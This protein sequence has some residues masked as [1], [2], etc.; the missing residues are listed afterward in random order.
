M[1]EIRMSGAMNG[2]WKRVVVQTEASTHGEN[3]RQQLLPKTCGNRDSRR[4]HQYF[5]ICSQ[6]SVEN[7]TGGAVT[8]MGV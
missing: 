5:R 7:S 8:K 4:F 6:L 1:R 3:C 2:D